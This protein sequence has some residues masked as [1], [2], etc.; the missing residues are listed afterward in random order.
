[1][2][3][4]SA[5]DWRDPVKTLPYNE[6]IAYVRHLLQMAIELE[7]ST[8]PLYL[9]A[10]YSMKNTS[11]FAHDVVRGV[12]IEEMLHMTTAA[13]VLN[14]IGGSPSID[15]PD[16]I[17]HFPIQVPLIN[18]SAS[19][20]PFDNVS[21]YSFQQIEL[22][23]PWSKSILGWYQYITMLLTELVHRHGE[24]TVFSGNPAFQV[25]ATVPWMGQGARKVHN[26]TSA[27]SALQAVA[28]Q[29]GGCADGVSHFPL[30]PPVNISAGPLGGEYSHYARFTEVLQGRQF[31]HNDTVKSGP[32]G[33]ARPT[34]WE[35][36]YR[37][38]SDPQVSNFPKG[39]REFELSL[40]FAGNYTEMLVGLHNAFNGA[41]DTLM[42]TIRQMYGLRDLATT[43]MQM[44][45]PRFSDGTKIGP[46]W[47][48]VPCVSHY[49]ARQQQTRPLW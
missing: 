35:Q 20:R 32:Q 44:E 7:H 4:A 19:I 3:N 46:P 9:T 27:V 49:E 47:E 12:V 48:Y 37:F 40:E 6:S 43:L 23:P 33:V 2:G 15:Q 30:P 26:L 18:M 21:V 16:F 5:L 31:T 39:S 1:M 13:N 34:D 11:T 28:D 36:V 14:A 38:E 22:P 25:E 24:P 42:S 45:D 17:P 41:P 10:M 8:I 29:G